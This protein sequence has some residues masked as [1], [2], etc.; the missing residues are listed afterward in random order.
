MSFSLFDVSS[1]PERSCTLIFF[2]RNRGEPYVEPQ[3]QSTSAGRF[4]ANRNYSPRSPRPP[5]P[6]GRLL[7][8]LPPLARRHPLPLQL[9]PPLL[10]LLL[11]S[12]FCFPQIPL[13]PFPLLRLSSCANPLPAENSRP[14]QNHCLRHLLFHPGRR[15]PWN[16]IGFARP[17]ACLIPAKGWGRGGGGEGS[18]V[19]WGEI[20]WCLPQPF[21]HSPR[22]PFETE[23]RSYS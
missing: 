6:R 22:I 12:R 2:V 9:P 14:R 8:S 17:E 7:R 5:L 4:S 20:S 10:S 21:D 16:L 13:F 1:W 19:G 3:A 18:G 15:T 11:R 23:L